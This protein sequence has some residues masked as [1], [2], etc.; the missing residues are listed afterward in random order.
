MQTSPLPEGSF[1]TVPP[2]AEFLLGLQGLAG[3]LILETVTH[4]LHTEDAQL[5]LHG[6]GIYQRLTPET[7]LHKMG[8]LPL[9][10][11]SMPGTYV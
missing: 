8:L 2:P 10:I 5:L 11:L 1:L 4:E 3:T 9:C 6:E 7:A